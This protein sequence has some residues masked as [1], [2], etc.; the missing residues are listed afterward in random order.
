MRGN[1]EVPCSRLLRLPA[2]IARLLASL[3]G[4]RGESCLRSSLRSLEHQ[5]GLAALPERGRGIYPSSAA[6]ACLLCGQQV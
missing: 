3:R 1:A 5:P 4:V 6:V 2:G